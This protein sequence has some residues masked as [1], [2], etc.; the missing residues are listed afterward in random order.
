MVSQVLGSG[1]AEVGPPGF[2][3]PEVVPPEVVPPEVVPPEVVPPEVVPPGV[4]APNAGAAPKGFIWLGP[5]PS[6]VEVSPDEKLSVLPGIVLGG[7]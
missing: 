7:A 4:V 5:L 2:G 1:T 6:D 3:P